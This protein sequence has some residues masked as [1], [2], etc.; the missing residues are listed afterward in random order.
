M[1]LG[2]YHTPEGSGLKELTNILAVYHEV[3]VTSSADILNG[4]F[5]LYLQKWSDVKNLPTA[6]AKLLYVK[7]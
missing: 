3:I 7:L 6:S 2:V 1:R 5:C 4:L